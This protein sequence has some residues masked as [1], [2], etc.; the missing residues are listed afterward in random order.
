MKPRL[1]REIELML[2]TDIVW[3]I[4]TYLENV[5]KASPTYKHDTLQKELTKIQRSPLRGKNEMYMKDLDDFIL[6]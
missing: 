2:P 6:D 3:L 4:S 5:K 1:P